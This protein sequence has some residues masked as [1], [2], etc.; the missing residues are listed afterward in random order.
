MCHLCLR[1]G[2]TYVSSPYTP[3][4]ESSRHPSNRANKRLVA[5]KV[6]LGGILVETG[7]ENN[8]PQQIRRII[9]AGK[10]AINAG[11]ETDDTE[12]LARIIRI[13]IYRLRC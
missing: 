4:G 13:G 8:E 3:G 12:Q 1:T 9:A 6:E 2:V 5:R 10:A 11:P 7:L